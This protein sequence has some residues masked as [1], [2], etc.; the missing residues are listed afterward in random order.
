MLLIWNLQIATLPLTNLE[1][2]LLSGSFFNLIPKLTALIIFV[3]YGAVI[4]IY[5]LL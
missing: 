4:V 2:Y 3:K 5:H 1:E